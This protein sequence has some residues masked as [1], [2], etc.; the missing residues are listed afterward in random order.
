MIKQIAFIGLLLPITAV[1]EFTA[2]QMQELTEVGFNE[3]EIE[4]FGVLL[5]LINK[6]NDNSSL[7][8]S[9]NGKYA[10]AFDELCNELPDTIPDYYEA[11]TYSDLLNFGRPDNK[12]NVGLLSAPDGYDPGIAKLDVYFENPLRK[13]Y[14][15]GYFQDIINLRDFAYNQEVIGLLEIEYDEE[16]MYKPLTELSAKNRAMV[17][18]CPATDIILGS[19]GYEEAYSYDLIEYLS[20]EIGRLRRAALSNEI[21]K[22]TQ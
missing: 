14:A 11:G 6:I 16:E 2:Q 17:S 4:S 12:Q 10:G 8:G 19:M 21:E 1:A 20:N 22:L 18:F 7:S 13:R 3:S 15:T 9:D 5:E